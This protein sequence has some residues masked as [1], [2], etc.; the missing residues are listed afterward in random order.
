M[1]RA[2]S[3]N[4]GVAQ[5]KANIIRIAKSK[6]WKSELPKSWRGDCEHVIL[7]SGDDA[8]AEP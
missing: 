7:G 4:Y 2:G 1:G 5:L 3:A 8:I 6:G